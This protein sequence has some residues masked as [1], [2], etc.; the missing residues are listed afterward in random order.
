MV[1]SAVAAAAKFRFKNLVILSCLRLISSQNF[2]EDLTVI[3]N[4]NFRLVSARQ[5]RM[6]PL[7]AGIQ[8]IWAPNSGSHVY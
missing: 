6:E 5:V 1:T 4:L 7:L 3:A 2:F 8:I